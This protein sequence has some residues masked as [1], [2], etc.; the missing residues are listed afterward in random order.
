MMD[1]I[2]FL[3]NNVSGFEA[4]VKAKRRGHH[5]IFM[6]S[7]LKHYNKKFALDALQEVDEIIEID[8]SVDV[9]GILG[10]IKRIGKIDAFLSFNDMHARTA[11]EVAKALGLPGI[12]PIAVANAKNKAKSRRIFKEKNVPSIHYTYVLEHELPKL[13]NINFPVVIKPT[14]GTASRFVKL[15]DHEDDLRKYYSEIKEVDSYGRSIKREKEFLI[16]KYITGDVVS[17]EMLCYEGSYHVL[18][19]TGRDISGM[20]FFVETG[21]YFPLEREDAD[22][23]INVALKAVEVLGIDFGF[24]H[25]ELILSEDGPVVIEVNPRLAGAVIPKLMHISTGQDPLDLVLDLH[26]GKRIDIQGEQKKQLICGHYFYSNRVGKV[27]RLHHLDEVRKLDYCIQASIT[28]GI[29]THIN[30][31][32]S[33][34]DL[35]GNVIFEADDMEDAKLKKERIE[36]TVQIEVMDD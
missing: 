35:I 33:N 24:C 8:S 17:V 21:F 13:K 9:P 22:E 25:V 31:L 19:L 26:L 12:D 2:I 23:I 3:E 27:Q 20:P 36:Q 7:D 11:A 29:G 16:E 18:G 15:L 28:K 10:E 34:F 5:V 32:S 4:M 6:T 30:G 1:R 14:D